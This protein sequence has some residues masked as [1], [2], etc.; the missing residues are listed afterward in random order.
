[1]AG[2]YRESVVSQFVPIRVLP[3]GLLRDAK[4]QACG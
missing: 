4:V 1:M 2:D 3:C